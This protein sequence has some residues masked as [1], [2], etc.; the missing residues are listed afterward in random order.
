MARVVK[1]SR[2]GPTARY[3]AASGR[4]DRPRLD[5][6]A[7]LTFWLV[8]LYG[9]NAGMVV[10]GF[11]AIGQPATLFGLGTF[12]W[13]LAA[14]FVPQLGLDQGPQPVRY[15]LLLYAVYLTASY[16]MASMRTLTALERTSS[17]R[18]MIT[19]VALFGVAAL[20][21]DGIGDLD[22]LRTL[23]RRLVT[24]GALFAAFGILQA[25]VGE[26]MLAL[27][28]GLQWNAGVIYDIEFRAG[29]IRPLATAMHPI[30]YSVIVAALVPLAVHFILHPRSPSDPPR[31]VLE[32]AL[33][34]LAVPVSLS[35]T[36]VLCLGVGMIVLA[37]G[38]SWRRRWNAALL[39][40]IIVPVVAA[41]VPWAYRVMVELFATQGADASVQARLDR[42]PRIMTLIRERPLF[43]LGYQTFTSEE[44]FLVD[45]QLWGL[46]MSVGIVG[47]VITVGLLVTAGLTAA[48]I[49]LRPAANPETIHLGRA[50]AGSIAAI[51]VSLATFDAFFYRILVFTLFLLIGAAGAL[52]RLTGREETTSSGRAASAPPTHAA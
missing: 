45:N 14:R 8:L 36:G 2:S 3:D 51:S 10:P 50:L 43:G 24:F 18:G 4:A 12:L 29:E 34:L 40:M 6:V 39:A 48:H 7:V 13:W 52:W 26:S 42:I 37:F 41:A 19:L 30:E 49:R 28:P 31:A 20:T 5:V 22:R 17:T 11:G 16:G 35:R 44:Y 38:W 33:L 25:V 1:P 47:L 23:L 15:A 9:I 27:P 32:A 46:I 21:A